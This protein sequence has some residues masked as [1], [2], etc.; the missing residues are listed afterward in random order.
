MCVVPTGIPWPGITE[1]HTSYSY[2]VLRSVIQCMW[3][4]VS[5]LSHVIPREDM[6][7]QCSQTWLESS[8]FVP[9]LTYMWKKGSSHNCTLVCVC[10]CVCAREGGILIIHTIVHVS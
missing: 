1:D 8:P 5:L 4:A 2:C 7:G 9:S 10:V 6:D 3:E